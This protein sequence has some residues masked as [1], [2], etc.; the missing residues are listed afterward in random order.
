MPTQSCG[1]PVEVLVPTR[2]HYK[3]IVMKCGNT[4]L[5]GYPILCDECSKSFDSHQYR[6]DCAE[7]GENIDED[8]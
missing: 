1:K 6:V 7:A 8:Y 3:T 5:D 4:G 2:Y